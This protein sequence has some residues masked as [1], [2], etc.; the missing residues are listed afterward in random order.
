MATARA[1]EGVYGARMTG[2]GLGGCVVCLTSDAA[3]PALQRH[4]T[5]RLAERFDWEPTL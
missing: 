4:L 5:E 1:T 2:T 3:L